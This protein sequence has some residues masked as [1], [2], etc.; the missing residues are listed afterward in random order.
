LFLDADQEFIRGDDLKTDLAKLDAHY[1]QLS[2]EEKLRGVM[3][4]AHY[5]P[6]EEDF[7]ASKLWDKLMRPED[8]LGPKATRD[9]VQRAMMRK[10]W[11]KSMKSLRRPA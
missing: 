10:S 4:F 5:P 7:L 6:V 2:D 8:G 3:C 9:E 11:L 1:S